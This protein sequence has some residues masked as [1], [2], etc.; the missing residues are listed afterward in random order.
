MHWPSNF[1]HFRDFLSIHFGRKKMIEKNWTRSLAKQK[2]LKNCAD[3]MITGHASGR[4][5]APFICWVDFGAHVGG[6]LRTGTILMQVDYAGHKFSRVAPWTIYPLP[7]EAFGQERSG[8]REIKY[9]KLKSLDWYHS[10]LLSPS[11][12]KQRLKEREEEFP[13]IAN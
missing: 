6:T 9:S 5:F 13:P 12:I 10:A 4:N 1:F 7:Q 2:Q 8:E 3:L 11:F